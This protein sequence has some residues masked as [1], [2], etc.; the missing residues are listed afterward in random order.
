MNQT[1]LKE[2]EGKNI[3]AFYWLAKPLEKR[4]K[5]TIIPDHLY[6]GV[7]QRAPHQTLSAGWYFLKI[8]IS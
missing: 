7:D 8:C 4:V 6:Q 2:K 3:E 1:I 5:S